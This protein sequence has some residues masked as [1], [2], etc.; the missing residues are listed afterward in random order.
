MKFLLRLLAIRVTRFPN[1]HQTSTS[2]A[3]LCQ[4]STLGK[5]QLGVYMACGHYDLQVSCLSKI[6]SFEIILILLIICCRGSLKYI[7][8]TFVP[9]QDLPL[10]PK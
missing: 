3:V 1:T 2:K 8:D 7:P 10:V 5:I 9:L 4:S 6:Q